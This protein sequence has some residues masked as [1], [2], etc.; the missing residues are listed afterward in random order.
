MDAIIEKCRLMNTFDQKIKKLTFAPL[1]LN[2]FMKDVI[3]RQ[4]ENHLFRLVNFDDWV[5]QS[6]RNLLTVAI[7]NILEN[8]LK[9]SVSGSLILVEV[10]QVAVASN[11]HKFEIVVTNKIDEDMAPDPELLFN[12]F[13]RHSL[14]RQTAGS[15]LGLYL[16]DEICRLLG[17]SI[18]YSHTTG[19]VK[20]HIEIP[21]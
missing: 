15:G 5:I 4:A 1:N 20:F 16:V 6:D 19:S 8:A 7:C 18:R 21:A 10:L 17:G 13:Y 2:E 9:Y 12:R 11:S 3:Q 14:A